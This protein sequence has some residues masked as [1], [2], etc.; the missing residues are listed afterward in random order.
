[1]MVAIENLTQDEISRSFIG[2]VGGFICVKL[3]LGALKLFAKL[4]IAFVVV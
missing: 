4:T 3:F 1:M 2:I